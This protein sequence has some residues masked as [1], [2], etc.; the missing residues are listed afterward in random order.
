MSRPTLSD[1]L[2]IGYLDNSG[3][4]IGRSQ[5]TRLT[6]HVSFR[7]PKWQVPCYEH[8]ILTWYQSSIYCWIFMTGHLFLPPVK[9][10]F[11]WM[12][13]PNRFVTLLV[14]IKFYGYSHVWGVLMFP[15]LYPH[16][17]CLTSEKEKRVYHCINLRSNFHYH[18]LILAVNHL[19]VCKWVTPLFVW[20]A[21]AD[22]LLIITTW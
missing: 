13:I 7:W 3:P 9:G 6:G 11:N 17:N 22:F 2:I 16:V 19:R 12:S 4:D 18:Q 14:G 10:P 1:Y 8:L 20:V 15:L 5:T 21:H